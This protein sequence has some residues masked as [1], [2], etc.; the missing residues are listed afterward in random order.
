VTPSHFQTYPAVAFTGSPGDHYLVG[1]VTLGSGTWN[2]HIH[3]MPYNTS[4]PQ[5]P[6]FSPT[7]PPNFVVIDLPVVQ[8]ELVAPDLSIA[9]TEYVSVPFTPRAVGVT[10][11]AQMSID[12]RLSLAQAETYTLRCGQDGAASYVSESDLGVSDVNA[13]ATMVSPV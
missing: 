5:F 10:G 7:D 9:A 6:V 2:V 13:T 3:L 12:T 4:S 1:F 8:C 11:V